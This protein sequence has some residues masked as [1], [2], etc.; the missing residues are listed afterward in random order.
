M[1][2]FLSVGFLLALAWG[3]WS[4]VKLTDIRGDL[5]DEGELASSLAIM[6][7]LAAEV[8]SLGYSTDCI[9]TWA[10]DERA[11][12]REEGTRDQVEAA[13]RLY[14]AIKAACYKGEDYE[15]D[16]PAC[17]SCGG[18]VPLVCSTCAALAKADQEAYE[19][20]EAT[21]EEKVEE[22]GEKPFEW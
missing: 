12:I 22:E 1:D 6:A 4:R 10:R 18:R 21:K 3:V 9:R 7:N 20:S 2:W 16:P 8:L 14:Q 13:D 17:P 11:F 5:W 15:S 19:A